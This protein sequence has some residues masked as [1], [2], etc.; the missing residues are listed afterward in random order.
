ML[1]FSWNWERSDREHHEMTDRA[2]KKREARCDRR[3]GRENCGPRSRFYGVRCGR[4]VGVYDSW[5]VVRPL[6]VGF[7]GAAYRAFPSVG[8]AWAYV[9][10]GCQDGRKTHGASHPTAVCRPADAGATIHIHAHAI[11]HHGK[12]MPSEASRITYGLH[13][14]GERTAAGPSDLSGTMAESI[15]SVAALRATNVARGRRPDDREAAAG[16]LQRRADIYAMLQAMRLV[17][18][19]L[20]ASVGPTRTRVCIV[21]ASLWALRVL[22]DHLPRW[23]ADGYRMRGSGRPPAD[24]DLLVEADCFLRRFPDSVSFA[25]SRQRRTDDDDDDDEKADT[26]VGGPA[27]RCQT[28]AWTE[29]DRSATSI[30]ARLSRPLAIARGLAFDALVAPPAHTPPS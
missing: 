1:T 30:A 11:V 8:A 3:S 19:A 4:A 15:V 28:G 22:R 29:T 9:E 25:Y 20:A 6:V 14:E 24:M 10:E 5:A 26:P 21:T 23:S 17:E 7:P 16:V 2:I 13:V 18:P 12:R 27:A